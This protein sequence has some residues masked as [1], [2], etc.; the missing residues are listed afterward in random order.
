MSR[1]SKLCLKILISCINIEACEL[2]ISEIQSNARLL[3]ISG[4][5]IMFNLD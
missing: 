3:E 2:Y 1:Y 4:V 5:R